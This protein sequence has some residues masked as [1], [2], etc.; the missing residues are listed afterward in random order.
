M[1]S[2]VAIP[3][4]HAR[5]S[6]NFVLPTPV[7]AASGGFGYGEEVA[8]LADAGALGALI[9]PT[10]TLSKC[11]GSPMPRTAETTGGLLHSLGWPN[12]GIANFVSD[13]LP[14]LMALRCPVLVSIRG[15]T[16][17]EWRE[18]AETLAAAGA[19][20][21]ELNLSALSL[22]GGAE[23]LRGIG[24]AVRAVRSATQGLVIAKLPAANVEIGAAARAAAAA[25]AD[26]IAVSQGFPGVA[27]RMSSRRFRLPGVSGDVSG[28]CIKPLALYQVWRAAQE[29]S[30]PI[31]GSGGIMT[32]EDALEFLVSGASAVAVGMASSIHPAVIARITAEI[33]E[34]LAK[35]H[36]AA[37]SDLTGAALA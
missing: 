3:D 36:F 24:E 6:P 28:P 23:I 17:E 2:A 30:C 5:L 34:Y 16:P 35:H 20:D 7:V 14:R 11:A 32:G 22:A 37:V 25:G 13:R 33:A 10:V 1:S 21:L 19:A 9:T 27:V 8:D 18:L 26:V 29:V 4:L 31:L 12:A 15:E